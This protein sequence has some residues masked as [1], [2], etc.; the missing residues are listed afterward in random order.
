MEHT[1]NVRIRITALLCAIFGERESCGFCLCRC[2]REAESRERRVSINRKGRCR[3]LLSTDRWIG[4][5]STIRIDGGDCFFGYK[6][7]A[8]VRGGFCEGVGA[9]RGNFKVVLDH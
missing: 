5:T 1:N 4:F 3:N 8:S 9:G 2:V 7:M 6:R